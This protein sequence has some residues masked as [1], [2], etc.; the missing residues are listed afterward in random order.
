MAI[1]FLFLLDISLRVE[2][3]NHMTTLFN[4]VR[5]CQ[6]LPKLHHFVLPSAECKDFN[7]PTT[8]Q[9]LIIFL[10]LAI[11]VGAEWYLVVVLSPLDFFHHVFPL[12]LHIASQ[13]AICA[14]M[15]IGLNWM[16]YKSCWFCCF[17]WFISASVQQAPVMDAHSISCG[18]VWKL[19][20]CAQNV[21]SMRLR[22]PVREGFR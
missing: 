4:C 3:L 7:C 6:I 1:A 12:Y 17:P 18:R 8:S 22:A 21:T 11:L 2:L 19:A 9:L 14:H 20:L 16:C 5:N 13:Y 10:I 15:L